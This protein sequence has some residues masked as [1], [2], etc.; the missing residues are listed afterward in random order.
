MKVAR[1]APWLFPFL[2]FP[3][4]SSR[5][6]ESHGVTDDDGGGGVSAR[7][8]ASSGGANTSGTG[9]VIITQGGGGGA[10]G[11]GMMGP[12]TGLKCNQTT[13]SQGA[14]TQPACEAGTS[15]TV[16]GTVYAPNGTLPLYNV[17]VYVPN[18]AVPPFTEGAGC[19]R[20]GQ[21]IMNPVTSTLTDTNGR[22]VLPDAPVGENVPLVIQ[23]GKWRRQVT[24]PSVPRCVDTPLTDVESTSLPSNQS[25]GDIPRIAITTGGADS[26]ECLPRRMGIEDSEFTTESGAGRIHLYQGTPAND[27]IIATTTFDDGTALTHADQLWSNAQALGA[28]DIVILSCEGDQMENDRPEGARQAVYDYTTIGGRLFASHWHHR[29]IS[30]GPDPF[31][32]TGTWRDRGNPDTPTDATINMTF[33]KGAALAEWLVNVQASAALGTM[34]ILEARDNIQEVN[35]TY[36]T[37]WMTVVNRSQNDSTAVEYLSFN[38]PLTVAESMKCGRVVYTDLHVSNAS[39]ETT[40]GDSPGNPFPSHCAVRDLTPQEKAVVFMLFDLSSCIQDETMEPEPP[41]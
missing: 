4:C 20:C 33:P 26:M 6:D 5:D 18:E 40:P 30:D 10:A 11:S 1:Y 16:S 41:R 32:A 12:C 38:T 7:G 14:C 2:L 3:A 22:F 35:A 8:G 27:E 25:E 24:I 31:P 28:Y 37:E 21:N 23:I 36:A 39:D 19:D 13:C 9:A 17:I 15:T 34:Q 29:W